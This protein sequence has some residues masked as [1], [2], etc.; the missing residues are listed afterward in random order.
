MIEIELCYLSG[1]AYI[2]SIPQEAL[3]N[4]AACLFDDDTVRIAWKEPER[5]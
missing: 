1:I 3:C 2:V 4:V 5:E